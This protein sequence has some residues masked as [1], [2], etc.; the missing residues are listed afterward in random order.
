MQ[1]TTAEIM[2][3]LFN[4]VVAAYLLKLSMLNSPFSFVPNW[5]YEAAVMI[6]GLAVMAETAAFGG[7]GI[8]TLIVTAA[9]MALAAFILWSIN[10]NEP[11][12]TTQN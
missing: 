3:T 7:L 10:K 11:A 1:G 4:T 5:L 12:A 8:S 9:A 6:A 2:A